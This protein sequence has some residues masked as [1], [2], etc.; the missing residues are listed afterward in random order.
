MISASPGR[1]SIYLLGDRFVPG[2]VLRTVLDLWPLLDDAML[3]QLKAPRQKRRFRAV[4]DG[5]DLHRIDLLQALE[6]L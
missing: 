6:A 3:I 1:A 2:G 5:S 4:T